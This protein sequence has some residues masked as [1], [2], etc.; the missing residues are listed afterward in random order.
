MVKFHRLVV[1]TDHKR[2]EAKLTRMYPLVCNCSYY[3]SW[4]ICERELHNEQH[5]EHLVILR[6]V[7]NPVVEHKHK[8]K[9]NN[10]EYCNRG[11][12]A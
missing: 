9:N 8:E 5:P 12:L 2:I 7:S 6:I 10:A 11:C 3:N 4:Y 1:T